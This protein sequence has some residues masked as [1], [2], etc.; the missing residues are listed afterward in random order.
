MS[1]RLLKLFIISNLFILSAC[2]S[3]PPILMQNSETKDIIELS[4]STLQC[5]GVLKEA[6]FKNKTGK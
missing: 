1:N 5:E 6:G 3:N 4:G 2:G